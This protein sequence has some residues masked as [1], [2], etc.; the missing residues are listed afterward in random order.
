MRRLPPPADAPRWSGCAWVS[1]SLELAA[2]VSWA[3]IEGG[4]GPS[5]LCRVV[6]DG[7]VDDGD[8][9]VDPTVM[10]PA[11][12][13]DQGRLARIVPLQGG[14]RAARS[15]TVALVV[16]PPA[17]RDAVYDMSLHGR[18]L[19]CLG[20]LAVSRGSVVR[21]AVGDVEVRA[22]DPSDCDAVS[23]ERM[24]HI[25]VVPRGAPKEVSSVLPMDID[26]GDP[27]LLALIALLRMPVMH[28]HV[29]EAARLRAP[30][31]VLLHGPPGVG[32]THM[33]RG[34]AAACGAHM[35]VINGPEILS[36][37]VGERYDSGVLA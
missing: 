35:V 22:V 15:V 2:G 7:Q 19:A 21:C 9:L 23:I 31:G 10:L 12:G 24:T 34:A 26:D 17:S 14:V 4:G 36:P 16:S 13:G 28:G 33:V 27:N 18:L 30:G 25:V 3:R 5:V 32:K 11:D 8:V 20:G 29:F 37:V 1:A 6:V